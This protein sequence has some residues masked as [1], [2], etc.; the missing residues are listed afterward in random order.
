MLDACFVLML[1]EFAVAGATR[2]TDQMHV[3]SRRARL[4]RLWWQV[5]DG[6]IACC[7]RYKE[8]NGEVDGDEMAISMLAQSSVRWQSNIGGILLEACIVSQMRI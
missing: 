6:L 3:G 2:C 8:N 1:R 5:G 7:T 4:G